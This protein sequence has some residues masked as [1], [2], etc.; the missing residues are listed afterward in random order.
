MR[1]HGALTAIISGGFTVFTGHVRGLAGFDRDFSNA[2]RSRDGR[3]TGRLVPPIL[4]HAG[5]APDPGR[6]GGRARHF[7][8]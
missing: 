7:A 1:R 4:D 8:R 6:A 5:Q 2:W 3:L